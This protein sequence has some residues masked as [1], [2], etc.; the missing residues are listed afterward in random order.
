MFITKYETLF[1]L[2]I[3]VFGILSS[4]TESG[5][6]WGGVAL[7]LVVWRFCLADEEAQHASTK[8]VISICVASIALMASFVSFSHGHWSGLIKEFAWGAVC[9]FVIKRLIFLR[10]AILSRHFTG[11]VVIF[12]VGILV[13]LFLC[14]LGKYEWCPAL[15]QPKMGDA[16]WVL[17]VDSSES[18]TKPSNIT[19]FKVTPVVPDID[20]LKK[21]VQAE[22]KEAGETVD[23]LKMKVYACIAEGVWAEVTKASTA[24]TANTEDTA[25][26]VL[27]P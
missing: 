24:L 6:L 12:S 20:S 27:V 23:P 16:Y 11:A 1:L 19:A 2:A 9:A 5:L 17:I 4:V 21:A 8:E 13:G 15:L 22:R 18:A 26:H 14:N 3:L 10:I 25:Y 7:Y